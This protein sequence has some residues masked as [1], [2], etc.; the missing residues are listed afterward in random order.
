MDIN[1]SNAFS[2]LRQGLVGAWCPS[3]PNGGSGNLLVDQ[4]GRG[5]NGTLTNMGPEDWVASEGGRALD[6]DG[7]D[8][9]VEAN[10]IDLVS[11]GTLSAWVKVSGN[12][13][14]INKQSTTS[15]QWDYAFYSAT[16]L[17]STRLYFY[18]DSLSPATFVISPSQLPSD[19]C[20]VAGVKTATQL[21]L[22]VNG[23]QVASASATNSFQQRD[24]K[25]RLGYDFRDTNANGAIQIDDARIYNRALTEAEIRL[26]ASKR[27]IGLQPSPTKFIAKE[28]KTGLR[29]RILTGQT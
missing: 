1:S 13:T 14:I 12:G 3:L 25:T 10:R 27:G 21:L 5:N 6:F 15:N 4:S 2:S 18:G 11:T 22:Y 28:K 16:N 8:D 29:R 20:H 9:V 26:L 19:W 23:I 7:V 17:G 24:F